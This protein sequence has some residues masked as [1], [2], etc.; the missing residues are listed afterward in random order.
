MA[1]DI[2]IHQGVHNL[3]AADVAGFRSAWQKMMAITGNP[4]YAWFAG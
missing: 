2:R 1:N 3:D 4:G